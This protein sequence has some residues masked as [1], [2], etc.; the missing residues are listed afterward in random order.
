M[1]KGQGHAPSGGHIVII[2][3]FAMIVGLSGLLTVPPLDRDESRFIQATTQMIETGDYVRIKYQDTERNK[4]PVG[5][6][7]LQAV[8]VQTLADLEDRPLWAFRLPS[9][10]GVMLA[11]SFTYVAGCYLFGRS[12]GFI[13]AV[14][15]AAAPVLAGE[16]SIAKTDAMLLATVCGMQAALARL[17]TAPP[18]TKLLKTAI[19]FWV[20]IGVGILI[21]GPITPMI[22]F[23]TLAGLSLWHLREGQGWAWLSR[24][25]PVMGVVILVALV[26]PWAVAIGITTEGRFFTDAIGTDMLGKITTGQER[27]G[28][29]IGYH[30]VVL[31]LM[32][33]PAALFIPSA[34]RF[35]APRWK[36]GAI[37][38]CLAWLIPSWLVFE[39]SSTKLPHYTMVLYPSLALL[40]GAWLTAAPKLD[41]PWMRFMGAGLYLIVG[42]VAAALIVYLASEYSTEGVYVWHFLASG[43]LFMLTLVAAIFSIQKKGVMALNV[44]ALGSGAFAWITFEGVLPSLDHLALTPRLAQMLDEHEAHPL[45]DDTGPIALVGYHEPSAVFTLGTDTRLLRPEEAAIWMIAA[46]GR[47]VVARECLDS[48]KGEECPADP[49][50]AALPETA[51]PYRVAFIDGFNYSNNTPTRLSLYRLRSQ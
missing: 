7:W 14:L 9:L 21:K 39:I 13:S 24:L 18:D 5:I 47:A 23:F 48:Q 12:A 49:F 34:V 33:W 38:F 25:R 27:H 29:P 8:S 22:G 3:I 43:L 11:A 50:L 44:A 2:A 17:I 28:G 20:A 45:R 19:G 31:W 51:E 26:A 1:I 37:L 36:D 42:T 35:A 10:I 4:K 40:V 6:Y 32:F 16:G 15:L 30:F 41:F 46:E